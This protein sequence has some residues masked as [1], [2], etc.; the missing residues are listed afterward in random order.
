[1]GGPESHVNTIRLAQYL[2]K[3]IYNMLCACLSDTRKHRDKTETDSQSS[4][5]YTEVHVLKG[6]AKIC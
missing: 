2:N 3:P 5:A 6:G 1:M 4:G